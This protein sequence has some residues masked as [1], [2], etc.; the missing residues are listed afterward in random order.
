MNPWKSAIIGAAVIFGLLLLPS[1]FYVVDETEQVII[2]EFGKP[3]G[4]PITAPGLY[5]KVPWI[6]EVHRIEKRRVE[7]DGRPTEMPT[8]DKTYLVVDAFA[9]WRVSDPETYFL[10][11]RDERSAQS[12]LDDIIG[13]EIRTV[14]A[15]H[16]LLEI[17]R[18]DK[19]RVPVRDVPVASQF[20]RA[21]AW[22]PI[23]TGRLALEK[24]VLEASAPKLKVF[25]IELL[26]VQF[27]RINYNNAVVQSI[28]QR[29]IS[30]RQQI[31]ERFR[32]EGLGEA[33]RIL[34]DREKELASIE[35]EAYR[36]VQTVRGEADARASQ[37]YARA[38]GSS[39]NAPEFF[40]FLKTLDTLSKVTDGDTSVI[41][42]TDNDVFRMLKEPA[43]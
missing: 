38:Y 29:M 18:S 26:N 40:R 30:E 24:Q 23:R 13:G 8:K 14:V 36:K 22:P 12:R 17:V 15:S 21:V 19:A 25:G 31:A 4:A 35:S 34:G 2:T 33:A 27:T 39:T 11:L 1:A 6:Q 10:R 5:F 37:I 42:S 28:Y 16:E 7:W 41:L 3:R 20:T 32:S 43:R 9:R